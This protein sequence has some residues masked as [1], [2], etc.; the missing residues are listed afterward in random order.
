MI[1]ICLTLAV[2]GQIKLHHSSSV[3]KVS[4][5][6]TAEWLAKVWPKVCEGYSDSELF[7][8]DETSIFV[9]T[10]DKTFKSKERTML[11]GYCLKTGLLFLFVVM[12]YK[13]KKNHLLGIH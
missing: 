3:G 7:N 6:A 5:E 9:L 11:V 13:R 4:G 12:E 1:H 8:A 2:F 10:P